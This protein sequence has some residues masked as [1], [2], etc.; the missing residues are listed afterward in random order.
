MQNIVSDQKLDED[1]IIFAFDLT[2]NDTSSLDL[3]KVKGFVV[4]N[5]GAEI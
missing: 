3:T 2:P 1:V 5:S 4:T